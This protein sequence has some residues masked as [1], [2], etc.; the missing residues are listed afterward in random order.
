MTKLVLLVSMVFYSLS[1]ACTSDGEEGIVPDND[2]Y[3][4]ADMKSLNGMEEDMFNDVITQVE[5]IFAP[6]VSSF[7]GKL[8]V[9]RKWTDGTVNA[10]AKR[11][12]KTYEV[13]MFGG[14]ARHETITPDALA[15]V[16]C[17]EIGHHIGGAPK[18]G[19]RW[20]SNEGQADY[21][22]S[23]KCLRKAWLNDNNKEIMSK[24]QV[25]ATVV[26]MCQKQYSQEADQFICQRSAM[27]G[28][29]TGD[30]FAA[31]RRQ[32]KKPSFDTPDK[33][34]VSKTNDNHPAPQC[35]LDTYFQGALCAMDENT[36]VDQK[37]EKVGTCMAEQGS[38]NIGVRPTC[39][40]KAGGRTIGR[41]PRTW[42][43]ADL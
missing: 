41:K 22:S 3:I 24:V 23:L 21:W 1:F 27:A 20:A 33:N 42:W 29:S 7:G 14:L 5:T 12:G 31:L 13:H 9:V 16:V 2:L 28:K 43:I 26:K 15:L 35:R 36:D 6:I 11:S 39:W 40:H 38:Q 18:K 8:K 25:P 10:Y 4:S 19:A 30:L 17:H 34:V 37:D 32:S